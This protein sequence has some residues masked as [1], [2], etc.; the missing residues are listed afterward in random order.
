MNKEIIKNCDRQQLAGFLRN[1]LDE[2]DKLDFLFHLDNC[3]NC[4]EE[5][6]NVTKAAHP[7]YYKNSS[8]K[9]KLSRK[10]LASI[11][12]EEEQADEEVFEV[13]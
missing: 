4:W 2:D 8:R 1:Q 6:Y 11:D 3:T 9:V 7:H 10:E 12:T 5:V 13:A